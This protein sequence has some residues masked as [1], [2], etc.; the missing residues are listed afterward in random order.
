MAETITLPCRADLAST[1]R[2]AVRTL[3]SDAPKEVLDDA[4]LIVTEFMA[5][6]IRWSRSGLGGTVDIVVDYEPGAHTARL[7][8]IDAGVLSKDH[9][10]D[11]EQHGRGLQIVSHLAKLGHERS[12]HRQVWWAE[13][14]WT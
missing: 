4:G 7:D 11:P 8:V 6:S 13:L 3:M 9:D 10:L 14:S 2:H 5:N 1:A 12:P